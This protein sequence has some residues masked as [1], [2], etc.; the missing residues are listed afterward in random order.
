MIPV[1]STNVYPLMPE[2]TESPEVFAENL[3]E[4]NEKTVPFFFR[5]D[6]PKRSSAVFEEIIR[7][8]QRSVLILTDRLDGRVFGQEGSSLNE[9]IQEKLRTATSGFHFQLVVRQKDEH[10]HAPKDNDQVWAFF[11]RM[12]AQYPSHF[13]MCMANDRMIADSR[14]LDEKKN[15]VGYYDF[16]VGDEDMYRIE[17]YKTGTDLLYRSFNG[18]NEKPGGTAAK[19]SAMFLKNLERLPAMAY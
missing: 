19:L 16:I 17:D 13:I 4:V 1:P 3:R 12:A 8:A 18:F 10:G 15:V 6:D 11:H 7:S 14:I 5:N 9:V 2:L